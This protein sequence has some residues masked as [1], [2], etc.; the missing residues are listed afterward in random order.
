[1]EGPGGLVSYEANGKYLAFA[2]DK[3]VAGTWGSPAWGKEAT[4]EEEASLLGRGE[5]DAQQE[6][7]WAEDGPR[8]PGRALAGYR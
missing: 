8:G 6:A 2:E 7:A 3:A 5:V 1:M 4:S